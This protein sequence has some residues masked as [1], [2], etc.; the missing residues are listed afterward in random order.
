MDAT[1]PDYL[2]KL[3]IIQKNPEPLFDS[4]A[5]ATIQNNSFIELE[6]GCGFLTKGTLNVTKDS[7]DGEISLDMEDI[8]SLTVVVNN[9]KRLMKIKVAFDG[10]KS[11]T[12][13]QVF[14]ACVSWTVHYHPKGHVLNQL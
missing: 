2:S 9:V 5:M 8:K 3:V 6:D 4:M 10:L 13:V 1:Q 12:V 11:C 14:Y 7:D